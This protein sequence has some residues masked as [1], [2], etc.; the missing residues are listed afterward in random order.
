MK[1]ASYDRFIAQLESTVLKGIL[2]K[3]EQNSRQNSETEYNE[4]TSFKKLLGRWSKTL[5]NIRYKKFV[6]LHTK[7]VQV[8]LRFLRLEL[9]D[10]Y[11]RDYQLFLVYRLLPFLYTEAAIDRC[12]VDTDN[13]AM[14]R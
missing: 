1:G 5:L 14:D 4:Y 8:Q 10:Q 9:L 2:E 12:V 6:F 3:T 7:Y 13:H 11:K